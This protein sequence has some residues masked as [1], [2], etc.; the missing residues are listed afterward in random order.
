[1]EL[2]TR[3]MVSRQKEVHFLHYN[4]NTASVIDLPKIN[5]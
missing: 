3:Q 1:M 5:Q 4:T 2:Y